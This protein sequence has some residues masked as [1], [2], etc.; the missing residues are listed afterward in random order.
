MKVDE[1][2]ITPSVSTD[3]IQFH[4]HVMATYFEPGKGPDCI[5]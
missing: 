1:C 5:S 2:L 3:V 4:K